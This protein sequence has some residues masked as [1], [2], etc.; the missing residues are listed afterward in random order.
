MPYDLDVSLFCFF[1][2]L[3][4]SSVVLVTDSGPTCSFSIS[5]SFI[6]SLFGISGWAGV[7]LWYHSPA[8]NTKT[9]REDNETFVYTTIS[10][11]CDDSFTRFTG[12][13]ETRVSIRFGGRS[14][15]GPTLHGIGAGS[16]E[17]HDNETWPWWLISSQHHLRPS[18]FP[19][20]LSLFLL[21]SSAPFPSPLQSQSP[22]ATAEASR[23]LDFQMVPRG[24]LLFLESL[25]WHWLSP[26]DRE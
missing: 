16:C 7:R 2:G 10:L 15:L 4:A 12:P 17:A 14:T 18:W 26:F 3:A 22:T 9:T 25:T 20:H 24:S 5:A 21:G 11:N 23:V 13:F 1:L 8:A 19:F 6:I